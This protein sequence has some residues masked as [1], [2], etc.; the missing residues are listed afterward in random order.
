MK[1]SLKKVFFFVVLLV[2]FF[3]PMGKNLNYYVIAQ[4]ST[5]LTGE[6]KINSVAAR[7]TNIN[8]IIELLLM[9][10]QRT[11]TAT[12]GMGGE[13]TPSRQIIDSGSSTSFTVTADTGY[14]HAESVGGTC[15]A[16]SWNGNIY[17]TGYVTDDCSVSF[18]FNESGGNSGQITMDSLAGNWRI[19]VSTDYYDTSSYYI[20]VDMNSDGTFTY[21]EED[22]SKN[23]YYSGN[24][25]WAFNENTRSF[26]AYADNEGLCSGT[27]ATD[28]TTSSFA[29]PGTFYD[30][31]AAIY[32]WV[33]TD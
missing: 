16:G 29:V 6:H 10:Q 27:L 31:N 8:P 17:T 5:S 25:T 23:Y 14:N 1:I 22:P 26:D 19:T 28:A 33:R 15:P 18:S 9:G 7:T 11:V 13:V 3:C 30:D 12:A 32:N 20:D 4:S 2:S 24:G 21:I